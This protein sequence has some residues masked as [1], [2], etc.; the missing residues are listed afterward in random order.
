MASPT[1]AVSFLR[2]G[3]GILS[4]VPQHLTPGLAQAGV[5]TVSFLPFYIMHKFQKHVSEESHTYR[6]L[7]LVVPCTRW[8][9]EEACGPLLRMRFS[10]L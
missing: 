3:G 9:S 4:S 6:V 10:N 5:M 2:R 8:Q 7:T 1:E